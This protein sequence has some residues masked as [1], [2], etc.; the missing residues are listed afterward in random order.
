METRPRASVGS[1]ADRAGPDRLQP[2]TGTLPAPAPC[3]AK[4]ERQLSLAFPHGIN[5]TASGVSN[6]E[7]AT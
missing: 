7:L 3:I 4:T 5:V 2:R 1:D 6:Q